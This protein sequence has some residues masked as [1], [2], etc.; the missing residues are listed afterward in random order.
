MPSLDR[1]VSFKTHVF[2]PI[3]QLDAHESGI[4]SLGMKGLRLLA[5]SG[6]PLWN[7]EVEKEQQQCEVP[8]NFHCM[9][10]PNAAYPQQMLLAGEHSSMSLVDVYQGKLI[11][12]FS[13]DM[14]E[15][16]QQEGLGYSG[17]V[18][19]RKQKLICCGQMN[20]KVVFRDP[21]SLKIEHRCNPLIKY[22]QIRKR[23][24]PP[25]KNFV[26]LIWRRNIM[27]KTI[28]P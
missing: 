9:I 3:K 15:E 5:R 17:T 16:Q 12:T 20:G 6:L 11:K 27:L 7:F 28:L 19:M 13:L 21:N 10:N 4:I 26:I 18:V 8:Y 14:E 25:L 22:F 1:H 2:G 24:L 23:D